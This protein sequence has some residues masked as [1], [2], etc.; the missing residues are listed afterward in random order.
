MQ[1]PLQ[2]YLNKSIYTNLYFIIYIYVGCEISNSYQRNSYCKNIKSLLSPCNKVKNSVNI[3]YSVNINS[4]TH[5]ILG[6]GRILCHRVDQF[7]ILIFLTCKP[8]VYHFFCLILTE[9]HPSDREV[10]QLLL[11][12]WITT[13]LKTLIIHHSSQ[14]NQ[15]LR[16]TPDLFHTLVLLPQRKYTCD[17][18]PS[19]ST[20]CRQCKIIEIRPYPETTGIIDFVEIITEKQISFT[21]EDKL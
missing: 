2:K 21:K 4:V 10:Q 3:F 18:C 13:Q 12:C 20:V 19:I 15:R 8:P 5:I 17:T 6:S 16:L 14:N 7:L 11:F 9:S 1:R